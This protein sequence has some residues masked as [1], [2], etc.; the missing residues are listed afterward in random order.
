MT[1]DHQPSDQLAQYLHRQGWLADNEAV[2]AVAKPGEGNMN[3]VARVTTERRSFIIKQ[4]YPWVYKYPQVTAPVDRGEREATFYR[5]I[6]SDPVLT[7]FT[8]TL[9]GYDA[10]H[11]VL[12]QEDL[13]SGADFTFLYDASAEMTDE[14]LQK[15]TAVFVPP[16]PRNGS[17]RRRAFAGEP[18]HAYAQPRTYLSLSLCRRQR[19]GLRHR[20]AGPTVACPNLPAGY[21]PET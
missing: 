13:G 12:A 8:P 9:L 20:A 21:D 4:A 6:A 15:P 3:F 10:H 1:L 17:P 14:Q 18:G 11:H 5:L 16:P 2:V 7:R 19:P